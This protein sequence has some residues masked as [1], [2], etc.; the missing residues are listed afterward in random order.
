MKRMTVLIPA[1]VFILSSLIMIYAIDI[2][3]QYGRNS[4]TAAVASGFCIWRLDEIIRDYTTA[5]GAY[6]LFYEGSPAEYPGE[7]DTIS[8]ARSV[9]NGYSGSIAIGLKKS[10]ELSLGY[11]F[12]D[13]LSLS[14]SKQSR[15]LSTGEY[16][17]GYWRPVYSQSKIIQRQYYHIDGYEIPTGS[18]MI[19]YGKKATGIGLKLE[20]YSASNLKID[21]KYFRL[22]DYIAHNQLQSLKRCRHDSA[23]GEIRSFKPVKCNI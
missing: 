16:V 5:Y 19:C 22:T 13:T 11:S 4:S 8:A 10:I 6:E 21:T 12:T 18:I 17:K 9:S 14:S 1:L 3:A 23:G 7:I 15:A 2:R 20:Y